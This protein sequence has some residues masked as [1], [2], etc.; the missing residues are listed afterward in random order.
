MAAG[1]S[2]YPASPVAGEAVP[3]DSGQTQVEDCWGGFPFTA[4]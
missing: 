2:H 1:Q 3:M 4:K